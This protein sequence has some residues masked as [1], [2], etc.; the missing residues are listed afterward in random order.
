MGLPVLFKNISI[1]GNPA[2]GNKKALKNIKKK[3]KQ[4]L[5]QKKLHKYLP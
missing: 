1:A 4:R 2:K 3:N 5:E